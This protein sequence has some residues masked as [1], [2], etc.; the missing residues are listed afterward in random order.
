MVIIGKKK[1]MDSFQQ[2]V[3]VV[4][5]TIIDVSGNVIANVLDTKVVVGR[6]PIKHVKKQL[7]GIYKK[8]GFVPRF[9]VSEEKAMDVEVGKV[10]SANENLAVGDKVTIKG[11]SKGKG[12]AGVMKRWGMK[13]GPKTRGQGIRQRHQGSIGAQTP[14]KVW[15]GKNMPGRTGV[16]SVKLSNVEVLKVEG[17]NVW[18]KGAVPGARGSIVYI[19]K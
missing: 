7:V 11:V 14:G 12:F 3:K 8:I 17:N 18:L 6:E 16:G 15:K 5:C 9:V 13:G 4:P 1:N 19:F 10:I 2:G